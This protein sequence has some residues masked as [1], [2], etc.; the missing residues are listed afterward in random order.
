MLLMPVLSRPT[1]M[2]ASLAANP[3]ETVTDRVAQG[4]ADA[5]MQI[6]HAQSVQSFSALAGQF[7]KRWVGATRAELHGLVGDSTPNVEIGQPQGILA[8]RA[9][10]EDATVIEA[11]P[12]SE[13]G[14]G[15]VWVA[16]ALQ[17]NVTLRA[18]LVC[19]LS[20]ADWDKPAFRARFEQMRIFLQTRLQELHALEQLRDSVSD[21]EQA[22]ALQRALFA[23]ADQAGAD[24]EMPEVYRRLHEIIASLMYAENFYIA[25]YD[26]LRDTLKFPY[27]VDVADAAGPT[28]EQEFSMEERRNSITWH[29]IK[30]GSPIRGTL[31][32]IES[33]VG[34]IVGYGPDCVDWLGVPLLRGGKVV[35][36]I[37]VQSYSEAA[38]YHERDQALLTYV[39]QHIQT[40]LER[41]QV[42]EELERRVAERTMRCAMQTACC[43]SRYLNVSAASGCKRRCSELPSWPT[44]PKVWK[45][46]T[47]RCIAPWVDSCMRAISTSP[48]CRT[49]GPI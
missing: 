35:G 13:V 29:L 30:R 40:A 45:R 18:A 25:I 2:P 41:R 46:F 48:C 17:V 4:W 5:M 43:S 22:E 14:D 23:I 38:R 20:G 34:P 21:L 49:T 26:P 9:I 10:V 39:A 15:R 32:Q 3:G 12:T 24:R 31:E 8:R 11:S 42:H 28:P 36:A 1:T 47:R 37:V 7:A 6:L 27:F 44:V 33:T 16:A 19:E